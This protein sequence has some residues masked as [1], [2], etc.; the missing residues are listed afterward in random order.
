MTS[1]RKIDANRANARASSGPKT[2]DGRARSAKNAFRH[3][4]SVSLQADQVLCE[5]V[6]TLAREIAGPYANARIQVLAYRVA[7]AQVDVRRV[8]HLRHQFLSDKLSNPHYDPQANVGINAE[9]LR[10]LLRRNVRN[11]M[12]A[13]VLPSTPPQGPNK[14]A[15]TLVQ[16]AKRLH[17]MDRYERRALSRRKFAVRALD[18]ERVAIRDRGI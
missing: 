7:E 10:G 11:P 3:G 1:N 16:E 5:E 12:A 8:R 6:Q 17:A 2:R 15:M 4:L 14:F 9:V 13:L 18:A